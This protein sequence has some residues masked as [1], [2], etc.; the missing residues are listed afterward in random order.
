V[1]PTWEISDGQASRRNALLYFQRSGVEAQPF[2]NAAEYGID[3]DYHFVDVSQLGDDRAQTIRSQGKWS[4]TLRGPYKSTSRLAWDIMTANTQR[5]FYLYPDKT[6]MG[7]YYYGSCWG[8]LSI[9]GGVSAA[10]TFS[11]KLSGVGQIG[12]APLT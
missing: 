4:G 6:T 8:T 9:T 3:I 10:D 2:S 12:L 11:M 1:E 7:A 5:K